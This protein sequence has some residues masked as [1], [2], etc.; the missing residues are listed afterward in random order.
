MPRIRVIKSSREF[1]YI[2][3]NGSGLN[4]PFFIFYFKKSDR[5][6]EFGVCAGKKLGGAVVRNRVKRRLR[7][8]LRF[9]SPRL[10]FSGSLVI[11]ARKAAVNADF[12]TLKKTFLDLADKLGIIS[13]SRCENL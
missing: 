10:N 4:S 12:L 2:I 9:F 3:K 1:S 6:S 7:E 5:P 11:V 13:S 8:I